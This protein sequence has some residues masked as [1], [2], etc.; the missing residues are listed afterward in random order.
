MSGGRVTQRTWQWRP[1]DGGRLPRNRLP[2]E[3]S[4]AKFT[5]GVI[6]PSVDSAPRRPPSRPSSPPG[7][8]AEQ[9]QAAPTAPVASLPPGRPL[10]QA[11]GGAAPGGPGSGLDIGPDSGSP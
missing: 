10:R 5:G 6:G 9:P 7:P 11:P 3:I 1:L 2:I 8:R 4:T